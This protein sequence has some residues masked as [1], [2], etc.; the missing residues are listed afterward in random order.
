MKPK[1]RS[2]FN[3]PSWVIQTKQ[4]SAAITH[5]GGHIAPVYF[6]RDRRAIQ[7]YHIAPW[8]NEKVPAETLPILKV[9]RG[10]FFCLPFGH[11]TAPYRGEKHPVHGEVANRLWQP[12]EQRRTGRGISLH[13]RMPVKVRRGTVDKR[14]AL[15][16]GHNIVYQ[17][18]LISG[19]TGPMLVG[20]HP[21]IQFP[22]RPASG[23]IVLRPFL[24]GATCPTMVERPEDGSYTFLKNGVTFHDLRRVPT[25][26][27][28]IADLSVYPN[29]RG[30]MDL[31]LMVNDPKQEFGWSSITFPR[32]GYVWFTLK[33]PRTLKA[34]LFWRSNGGRWADIWRGR[35]INC[36]G[37]ED[38]TWWYGG[39]IG[40]CLKPNPMS[41]RG[42]KPYLQLSKQRPTAIN[43]IQGCVPV[44]KGF[45]EVKKIEVVSDDELVIRG[46]AGKAVRV[47]CTTSFIHT[48]RLADLI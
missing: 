21:N 13:L 15:V 25:I 38:V 26:W 5:V 7:P 33:D 37:I 1:L 24:F 11:N 47:P 14:L 12:I 28:T 45:N 20:H 34:T 31:A 8:W 41:K 39:G 30:F 17:Q 40:D 2:V 32:E 9:L 18:N 23:K 27:G 16:A 29:Y 19:M 44:P 46:N 36:L 10:D 3:Q 6:N 42:I 4:V 22:D 48:G 43:Y 35:H